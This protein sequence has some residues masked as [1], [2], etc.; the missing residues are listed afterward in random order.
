MSYNRGN[1][2]QPCTLEKGGKQIMLDFLKP[3]ECDVCHRRYWSGRTAFECCRG[4]PLW[5]ANRE[6]V[7]RQAVQLGLDPDTGKKLKNPPKMNQGEL[8]P[9]RPTPWNVTGVTAQARKMAC[10]VTGAVGVDG[11]LVHE[12]VICTRRPRALR[13]GVSS[14]VWG[15]VIP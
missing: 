7:R 11:C 8:Y 9:S 2:L 10:P 12:F 5:N 6:R 3:Y 13:A 4:T 15:S 14:R 1:W